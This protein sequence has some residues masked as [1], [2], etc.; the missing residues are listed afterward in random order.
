M[1]IL[2]IIQKLIQKNRRNNVTIRELKFH[3]FKKT[4]LFW[5]E[6]KKTTLI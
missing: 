4:I 6:N 5:R 3:K 2:Q 1:Q